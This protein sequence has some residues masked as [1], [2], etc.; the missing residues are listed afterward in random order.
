MH[1]D[2]R[3]LKSLENEIIECL[4]IAID[5]GLEANEGQAAFRMGMERLSQATDLKTDLIYAPL[6]DDPATRDYI[7]R[8]DGQLSGL[9]ERIDILRAYLEISLCSD[10]ID[11]E[12]V[13]MSLN[14]L[15]RRLLVLFRRE[16]ALGPVYS[17][18]KKRHE[19]PPV[20]ANCNTPQR[21]VELFH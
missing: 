10:M 9:T 8:L 4:D 13:T 19:A 17:S 15:R 21:S 1:R 6:A 20:A 16:A 7:S 3:R 14:R 11:A 12:A 18:W 5:C 2:L